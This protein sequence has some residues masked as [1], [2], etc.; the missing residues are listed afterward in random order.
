MDSCIRLLVCQLPTVVD[1]SESL[2]ARTG[3]GAVENW[4][5]QRGGGPCQEPHTRITKTVMHSLPLFLFYFI[6]YQHGPHHLTMAAVAGPLAALH[7]GLCGVELVSFYLLD[8]RVSGP[9]IFRDFEIESCFLSKF[10][11]GISIA[12]SGT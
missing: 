3:A 7:S 10:D 6:F 9:A 8:L 4:T 5:P 2:R 12:T 1:V 11:F